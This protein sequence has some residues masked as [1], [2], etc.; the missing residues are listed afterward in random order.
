MHAAVLPETHSQNERETTMAARLT[1]S[2]IINASTIRLAAIHAH[3]TNAKT[4]IPIAGQLLKPAGV[5]AIFQDGLDTRAS[6]AAL[7]AQLKAAR[8]ARDEA[9]AK[10]VTADVALGAWVPNYFG[11][12]SAAAHS[13][14]YTPR[15][16]AEKSVETKKQAIE[17]NKATRAARH[18]MGSKQK[19]QIKG[20]MIVLTASADPAPA[21]NQ[22]PPVVQASPAQG[23]GQ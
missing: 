14:G 3:L 21:A 10:R 18:T 8:S 19:A 11:A 6:V 23:T 12:D 4:E 16:V 13:F 2:E 15:K 5:A 20:T 7:E 17:R 1:N 22:P 9:E